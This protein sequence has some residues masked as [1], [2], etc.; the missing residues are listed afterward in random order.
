MLADP[1]LAV[2]CDFDGTFSVQDVGATLAVRHGGPERAAIWERTMRG[3]LTPW[4]YNLAVLDGLPLGVEAL[5]EFLASVDLDPGATAL[6]GWCEDREVPFRILSDGF[7]WN[8]NRLQAMH[9]VKFAY[10]ANHLRL[11][12][13]RWHIRAGAPDP[14]CGCGTGTCKAAA[15]RAYR[16][17]HPGVHLVHIG[18]G[19]VSDTCGAVEADSAFAKDSLA[20]EL[21]RRGEP[22]TPFDTLLDVIPALEGL[23]ASGGSA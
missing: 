18:N 5:E 7:D 16:A 6:L 10:T 11:D 22:F 17:R 9:G 3:E 20:L 19:R 14:A 15:L 13:G 1:L 4:E 2:F 8:L 21:D 23:L 12:G